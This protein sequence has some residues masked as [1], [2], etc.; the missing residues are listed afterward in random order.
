MIRRGDA[1]ILLAPFISHHYYFPLGF[2]KTAPD[3]AAIN[4]VLRP[5]AD[6]LEKVGAV[7]VGHGHYDHL[8]DV[9]E[10][11]PTFSSG[12]TVYGSDTVV[13][14]LASTG[15]ATQSL[16]TRAERPNERGRWTATA[17][18]SIRFMAISSDHTPN[19]KGITIGK[20]RTER[21][22][23][24]LPKKAGGWKLGEP[25]AYM[26]D[27]LDT[28]KCADPKRACEDAIDFRIYYQDA[29]KS[30]DPFH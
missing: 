13:N 27:F 18:G 28:T 22:L 15:L 24:Q 17:G 6:R 8:L 16:R 14:T 30:P 1:A 25:F 10:F 9:S 20:G 4:P 23:V 21:G 2:W 19:L 5:Y 7:L 12:A 29:G 11:V 3:A 26:I